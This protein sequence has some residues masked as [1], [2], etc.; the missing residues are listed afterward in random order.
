[1]KLFAKIAPLLLLLLTA[2]GGAG[3][4]ALPGQ[5]TVKFNIEWPLATRLVPIASKSIVISVSVT[6]GEGDNAVTEEV[7]MRVVPRPATGNLST[8]EMK[9]P[10]TKLIIQ[11]DASPNEDGTGNIQATGQREVIVPE[12]QT[13]PV[14]ITM[15]TRIRSVKMTPNPDGATLVVDETVTYEASAESVGDVLVITSPTK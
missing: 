3:N 12:S 8:V 9:L 10:S 1:M 13:V 7:A 11:A 14:A 15:V 6:K 4:H 2:C 5:G